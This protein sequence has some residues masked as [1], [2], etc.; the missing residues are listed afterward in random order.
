MESDCAVVSF[1]LQDLDGGGAE[2]AVIRLAGEVALKGY[3]VDL[4][5]GYADTDYRPEINAQVNLIDFGS[6]SPTVVFPK[7]VAY[8]RD[9]PPL[10]IMSALD[11][12]N[13]MLLLASRLAQFSGRKVVSQRA[14]LDASLRDLGRVRR[15]L[16]RFLMAVFFP[17]ADA[18]ISNSHAAAYELNRRLGIPSEKIYTIHNAIDTPLI[19]RLA[20]EPLDSLIWPDERVPLVVSVGSLTKRKDVATLI[21]A[22]KHAVSQRA[23]RLV[24][25]G[26]GPERSSL[27]FLI[28]E[29]ELEK[30]VYLAGFNANPYK[31]IAAASVFVS[32]STEEGFPNVIAE[33][34]AL[35]CPIVA[36]D[37]PGDTAELLGHGK[38]GRLVSV[39]DVKSMAEAILEAIDDPN[40]SNGQARASDF[41]PARNASAYLD[42]LLPQRPS[43]FSELGGVE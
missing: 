43:A 22:F 5:V 9:R 4:V 8:L 6:R 20:K 21:R 12:A 40:P 7:L 34:L 18:L 38:W 28:Q 1:F 30:D 23:A 32:A 41:T 13:I 29:L 17:R 10:V 15:W 3:A 26:E 19:R 25:I 37:C 42:V 24:I 11:P 33:S 36:T 35:G 14:V 27:E 31:W 16:T 2:R 39:G